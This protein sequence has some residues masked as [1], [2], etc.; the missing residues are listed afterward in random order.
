MKLTDLKTYKL[1]VFFIF[2]LVALSFFTLSGNEGGGSSATSQST[3][4]LPS[5]VMQSVAALYGVFI[6]IFILSLQNNKDSINSIANQIKP[7]LKIVSYTAAG[8][9]YF[10]G[11]I[12]IVFSLG[13]FSTTKMKFML[14]FSLVSMVLS[15]IAIVYSSMILLSDVSGLKTSSEK[16]TYISNL[17]QEQEGNSSSLLKQSGR[18]TEFCIKAIDDENPEVRKIAAKALEHARD[19]RAENALL[20]LLEDNNLEVR[21]TAVRVLGR[22]GAEN[23]V[24]PLIKQLTADKDPNF[25]ICAIEALG[26]LNDKQAIEPL[27]KSLDDK[28]SEVKVATARSLGILGDERAEEALI[29]K[30]N[31]GSLEFHKQVILALGKIGDKKTVEVLIHKLEDKEPEIRKCTAE[32]LGK[33]GNLQAVDPLLRSINDKIPEVR[34]AAAYSLGMLKAEKAVDAL[35]ELL[36]EE[37]SELRITAVYALGSIGSPR[38]VDSLLKFLNDCN[39]WIRRYAVEALGKIGDKKATGPLVKNLNDPDLEVRW[40][41]A[42]ALR[43]MD[44]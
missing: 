6:A 38:S 40:A 32:S 4:W 5:A 16:F 8:T 13:T 29:M 1:E 31:K 12:L 27:I 2:A 17:L 36:T 26:N 42:E 20:E 11:L 30:L 23:T 43:M 35:E 28:N 10:N 9:I 22:I 18:N 25:R 21:I 33:L 39:P 7:T 14:S 37:D 44:K 19:P 15:L 3:F 24:E 34:N 41:T